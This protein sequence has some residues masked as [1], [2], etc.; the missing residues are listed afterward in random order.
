MIFDNFIK[1]RLFQAILSVCLFAFGATYF[2]IYRR[3]EKNIID[4][5]ASHNVYFWHQTH[6]P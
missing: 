5:Q 3:E 2:V 6:H 4:F 1:V